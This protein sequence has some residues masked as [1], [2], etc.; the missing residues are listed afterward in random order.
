MSHP[1][2]YYRYGD[3]VLIG[4][5]NSSYNGALAINQTGLQIRSSSSVASI[6][7]M[8]FSYVPYPQLRVSA[9]PNAI[10][11]YLFH[12]TDKTS[13]PRTFFGGSDASWASPTNQSTYFKNIQMFASDSPSTR[14][15][16][17]ALSSHSV[18]TGSIG[19]VLFALVMATSSVW[20]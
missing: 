6:Q 1:S 19:L 13:Y 12:I 7:G 3:F 10:F 17:G 2:Y 15:T 16:S 8:F 4:G 18:Q 14:S 9:S 5:F 20:A 11:F